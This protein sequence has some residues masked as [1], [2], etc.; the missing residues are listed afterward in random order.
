MIPAASTTPA[1]AN[2]LNRSRAASTLPFSRSRF[3]RLR[4]E[5]TLCA[6]DGLANGG[7]VATSRRDG[8]QAWGALARHFLPSFARD[9][10]TIADAKAILLI[11]ED[12]FARFRAAG[13]AF[14]SLHA[15][16]VDRDL[17]APGLSQASTISTGSMSF[18]NMA[19]VVYAWRTATA[20]SSS[21]ST[22]ECP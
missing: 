13:K 11:V 8:M 10:V 20:T 15:C 1:S 19:T 9:L 3:P 12:D 7:S 14:D 4:R 21:D 5:V 6:G 2:S 16:G 17:G 22:A 18:L